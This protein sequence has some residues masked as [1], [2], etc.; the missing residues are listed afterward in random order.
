[1]R[2]SII[3]SVYN[4]EK[5]IGRAVR[6]C[7]E[8]N[9]PDHS[10]EI[11]V[12]NDGSTDNTVKILDDFGDRIKV[13]T[14][15]KNMGLPYACNVGIRK[16]LSP[17]VVRVDADDFI[18]AEL[19]HIGNMFL[20]LNPDMDAVAFDYYLVD[21][22]GEK[23]IRK[24]AREAPIACGIFFRK[25][26]LVDIGLYD[27]E[28]LLAED[29]DLRIRFLKKYTISYI[30]LPLYRYRMHENNSTNNIDKFKQYKEKL[31]TKHQLPGK[32]S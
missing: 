3:I 23:S 7:L 18:Q 28:F 22:H 20:S 12:V 11:I 14:L 2:V 31:I 16:A 29:E 19:L 30:P 10:Y 4:G 9:M 24:S 27:E 8:Q 1:M 21:E 32:N 15:G 26:Y 17:F 6:S 5:F 25:D 13:I